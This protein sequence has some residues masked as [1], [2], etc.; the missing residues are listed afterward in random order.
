ML[1]MN[2]RSN[3][4]GGKWLL[5]VSINNSYCKSSNV[6]GTLA[7]SRGYRGEALE[8]L[9]SDSQDALLPG[10]PHQKSPSNCLPQKD[11]LRHLLDPF[12]LQKAY[13]AAYDVILPRPGSSRLYY[14]Q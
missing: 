9:S 12:P 13:V 3:T 7:R 11:K 4:Y 1:V 2:M 10:W 8:N 5:N 14:A 6:D